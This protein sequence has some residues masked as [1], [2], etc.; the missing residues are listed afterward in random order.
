MPGKLYL[1][2][3][4]IS[5]EDISSSIPMGHRQIIEK[6]RVFFVEDEKSARRFLKKL[7][8]DF[9]LS[10]STFYP[11][12]EHTP[13]KVIQEN[14]KVLSEYDA[15][16]ISQAGCPCVADP[17]AELVLL[18]HQNGIEVVPLVG[19]SSILLALMASGLN[20]QNF[21]FNGYLSR[22]KGERVKKIRQLEQRSFQEKQTQ[23]FM[24][25]PYRNQNIFEDILAN[26]DP[27]TWLSIA[28][29]LNGPQQSVKTTTVKEWKKV[30]PSLNK[31][32]VLFLLFKP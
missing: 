15:G 27:R 9:P 21:A 29:D 10:E 25:T 6:I 31:K 5:G 19:P 24:E 16:V 3:T 18:T 4:I 13:S 7:I 12:N 1:I 17:G 23:I 30:K 32:P 28:L 14:V 26:A 20:G 8:S 2:P 11:L 22:E